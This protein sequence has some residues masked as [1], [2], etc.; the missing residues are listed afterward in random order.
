MNKRADFGETFY[1]DINITNLGLTPA[2]YLYAKIS[3]TSEWATIGT[4]SVYIG[5]LDPGS[6]IALQHDL[7]MTI[8]EDVPDLGFIPVVLTLKDKKTLKNFTFDI[9]V[10][11]PELRIISCLLDDKATGNG[12][13]VADPGETF[14]LV[15]RVSNDGSSNTSGQFLVTSLVPTLSILQPSVKSGEIKFG[16]I[17]DIRV[18]VK[19]SND[20]QAGKLFCCFFKS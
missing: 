7:E 14:D 13:F 6:E 2:E 16:E 11:A 3:S 4:D 9:S 15:F 1:L 10:H 17:T 5:T 18:Q 19:L 8:I 12:D 20:I